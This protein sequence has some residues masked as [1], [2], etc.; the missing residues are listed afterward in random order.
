MSATPGQAEGRPLRSDA[1]N[2]KERVLVAA[3]AAIRRQGLKVPIAEIAAAAGVGVGTVYRHYPS[4]ADLIDALSAR[5]YQLVLE[6]ARAAATSQCAATEAITDFLEQTIAARNDLIL[7]LHSGP[8]SFDPRTVALRTEISDLLEQVLQRGRADGTIRPDIG[9]IDLII[10]GAMLA[11]PLAN[12][13]NWDQL[14]RRQVAIFM[15]GI[16]STETKPL[17]GRR[18]E[19]KDLETGF[20]QAKQA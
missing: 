2:N 16:S 12:T 9:A 11:Q 10:T 8:V 14:A 1:A 19:R 5:S 4:R 17:P 13:P 18:P 7:P 15:S 3:A 20:E 6:H